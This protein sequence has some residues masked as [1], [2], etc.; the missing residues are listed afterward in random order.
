MRWARWRASRGVCS[1]RG[2]GAQER[3]KR[4]VGAVLGPASALRR[5]Q[6]PIWHPPGHLIEDGGERLRNVKHL[7]LA[8]LHLGQSKSGALP[9]MLGRPEAELSQ[10]GALHIQRLEG[11]NGH[12]DAVST[13]VG[14]AASHTLR[15]MRPHLL[16]GHLLRRNLHL[17]AHEMSPDPSRGVKAAVRL[18]RGQRASKTS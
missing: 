8:S 14:I 11:A 13:D 3:A 1:G 17:L 9:I 7:I 5:H 18:D 10:A 4:F 12:D 6:Q 16:L 2:P 15:P